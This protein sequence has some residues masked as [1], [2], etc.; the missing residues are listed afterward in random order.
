MER[1]RE[2]LR[3][4]EG[5]R[6]VLVDPSVAEATEVPGHVVADGVIE[7]VLVIGVTGEGDAV[8]EA[9]VA[10]VA[11]A[12][13]DVGVVVEVVLAADA[14]AEATAVLVD[15]QVAGRVVVHDDV[16]GSVQ[17]G[18]RR[19]AGHSDDPIEASSVKE[20][21]HGHKCLRSGDTSVV[22]VPRCLLGCW[23]GHGVCSLWNCI[24]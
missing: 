2:L 17:R 5:R 19:G 16:G 21:R 18:N 15:D 20:N 1:G 14:V 22:P 8:A 3:S 13:R 4:D 11:H 10:D 23:K 7:Q 9:T 6:D 24:Q 12:A